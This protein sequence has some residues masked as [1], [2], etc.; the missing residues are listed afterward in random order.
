MERIAV[1]DEEINATRKNDQIEERE[2]DWV[3]RAKRMKGITEVLE[4]VEVLIDTHFFNKF[5][6]RK[7]SAFLK[8]VI[9]NQN[10]IDLGSS[11]RP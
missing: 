10:A 5:S 8:N 9:A 11:R 2:N 4:V 7:Q 1:R 6:E 3:I